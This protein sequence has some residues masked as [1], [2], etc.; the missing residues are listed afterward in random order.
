M[1]RYGSEEKFKSMGLAVGDTAYYAPD[2]LDLTKPVFVEQLK[3]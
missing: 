3:K 1:L 2:Y